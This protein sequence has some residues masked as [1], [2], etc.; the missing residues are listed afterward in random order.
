MRTLLLVLLLAP[1]PALASDDQTTAA[2]EGGA[3]IAVAAAAAGA[4]SSHRKRRHKEA[5][6]VV[7]RDLPD[8]SPE[9]REYEIKHLHR[10]FLKP[11]TIARRALRKVKR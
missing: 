3:A 9:R 6:E 7:D 8:L 10:H 1:L 4:I 2:A 11:T 5:T